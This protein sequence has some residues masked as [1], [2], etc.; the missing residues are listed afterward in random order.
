MVGRSVVEGEAMKVG[1]GGLSVWVMLCASSACGGGD[2]DDGQGGR[3][4]S[5]GG[6][7]DA[8]G[9]SPD[10]G[11]PDASAAADAGGADSST[12]GDVVSFTVDLGPPWPHEGHRVF[13]LRA[14]DSVVDIVLTDENGRAEAV[15]DEPGTVVAELRIEPSAGAQIF[16]HL[17]VAP[18]THIQYGHGLPDRAATLVAT[19][20]A[21]ESPFG[22]GLETQC[23]RVFT[24]NTE[25]T[26]TAQLA[27][28]PPVV[29]VIWT[30]G[31]I[32]DGQEQIFSVFRP[33]VPVDAGSIAVKGT[34]RP[35]VVQSTRLA[36]IPTDVAFTD[37]F[38]RVRGAYGSVQETGYQYDVPVSEGVAVMANSMH[39]LTGLGLR[40]RVAASWY[41]TLTD[42]VVDVS[43][44]VLHDGS[45]DVDVASVVSPVLRDSVFDRASGVWT[46]TEDGPNTPT[47]I[48]GFIYLTDP[49][50]PRFWRVVAPRQGT[51]V[52][53]PRLPA[54][55][56]NLNI[57]ADSVVQDLELQL[58]THTRGYAPIVAGLEDTLY[59]ADEVGDITAFTYGFD[60]VAR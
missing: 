49:D 31:G 27:F 1:L 44:T 3:L 34:L 19:G 46:W 9:G 57:A 24:A 40:G 21:P 7:A 56:E 36:G 41:Q 48:Q 50:L 5:G 42:T 60:D 2:D 45:P 22:F 14:D 20:P 17:G 15:F 23:G 32:V 53:L 26:A 30:A 13:F 28:C 8:S 43:A 52:R 16:A 39:D 12:G 29:D 51:S 33:S 47:A 58:L 35:D 25:P 18:G 6:A 55:Y 54:P 10:G 37:M 4:D 59:E 38:Y 11:E